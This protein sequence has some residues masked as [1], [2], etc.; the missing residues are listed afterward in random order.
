MIHFFTT[1]L[2]LLSFNTA[3]PTFSSEQYNNSVHETEELPL[4]PE[5]NNII[6]DDI[7]GV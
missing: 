3:S 6:N 7:L 4:S 2:F 1:I 5:E